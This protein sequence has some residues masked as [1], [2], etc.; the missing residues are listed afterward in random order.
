M[1]GARYV[2]EEWR[3][4]KHNQRARRKGLRGDLRTSQWL[5]LLFVWGGRCAYC[6][7]LATT[8]DHIVPLETGGGTFATNVLPACDD[9][10]QRKQSAIWLP[11]ETGQPVVK[12]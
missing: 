5:Y 6:G 10:N 11:A 3:V 9:C 12:W 7:A 2:T 4:S 1:L 8:L